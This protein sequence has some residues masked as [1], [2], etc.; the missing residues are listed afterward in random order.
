M[1]WLTLL[2]VLLLLLFAVGGWRTGLLRRLLELAGVVAAVMAAAA[3]S[4]QL[5]RQLAG[6]AGIDERVVVPLAWILLLVAGVLASRL[7]ARLV[8]GALHAVPVVGW[9]DRSG[10]A[11]L[12][13]C[14]GMLVGSVVLMVLCAFPGG[15]R[16][17]HEIETRP[18]PRVV[19]GA[20][21]ALAELVLR[22]GEGTR[23]W[24]RVRGELDDLRERL[25]EADLPDLPDLPDGLSPG[26]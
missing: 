21:P 20:A 17:Q 25:P 24:H 16:M 8:A 15:D 23:L 2:V 12:G 1:D 13:M 4:P 10:G 26:R 22:D 3:W 5:A 19:Y 11:V 18:L 6:S 7:L 14:A 9:L